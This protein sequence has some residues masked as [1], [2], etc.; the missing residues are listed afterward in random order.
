MKLLKKSQPQQEVPSA[1]KP[2]VSLAELKSQLP[3][4]REAAEVYV[5]SVALKEKAA[6]PLQ[7]LPWHRM[8]L[9]PSIWKRRCRVCTRDYRSRGAV[10]FEGRK[11]QWTMRTAKSIA[12]LLADM[13]AKRPE[14]ATIER[15]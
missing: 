7:P 10:G 12:A 2:E 14:D 4:A 13:L 8:Q 6:S 1:E 5:Q 3:A 15:F 9:R 11:R